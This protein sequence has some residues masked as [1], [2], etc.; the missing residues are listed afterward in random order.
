MADHRC[1]DCGKRLT[2]ATETVVGILQPNTD[3]AATLR[4]CHDCFNVT[5]RDGGT[6][7]QIYRFQR[8]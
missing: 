7:A 4:F 3:D 6:L 8:N 5:Y 1:D 2:Q